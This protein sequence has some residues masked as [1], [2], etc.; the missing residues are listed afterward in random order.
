MSLF[1]RVRIEAMQPF[2]ELCRWGREVQL[3]RA[4][5]LSG[6]GMVTLL[7]ASLLLPPPANGAAIAIAITGLVLI[8]LQD[9]ATRKLAKGLPGHLEH[10]VGWGL[11]RAP[12]V[13]EPR[14]AAHLR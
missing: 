14:L 13:R 10:H 6:Q 1:V 4:A 9:A 8:A 5:R 2:D 3:R 7:L 12:Q 11:G